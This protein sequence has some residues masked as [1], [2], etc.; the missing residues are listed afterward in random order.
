MKKEIGEVWLPPSFNRGVLIVLA[1]IG[2]VPAA[3]LLLHHAILYAVIMLLV[4]A[5]AIWYVSTPFR[6]FGSKQLK[7]DAVHFDNN[8]V[9]M[10][11]DESEYWNDDPAI[12]DYAGSLDL[13]EFQWSQISDRTVRIGDLVQRLAV[14]IRIS[15]N[16]TSR[17]RVLN[18]FKS[19]RVLDPE[20]STD[21]RRWLKDRLPL[22]TWNVVTALAIEGK[23][24]RFFHENMDGELL[25]LIQRAMKPE[26]DLIGGDFS[27]S[28]SYQLLDSNEEIDEFYLYE[29]ADNAFASQVKHVYGTSPCVPEK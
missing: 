17:T 15:F 14:C 26:L 19:I 24:S 29:A 3:C 4:S 27:V 22:K 21:W 1:L 10:N 8:F 28:A 25:E 13:A 16:G 12:K 20:A 6:R 7:A 23:L 18:L 11:L 9:E 5:V 2:I